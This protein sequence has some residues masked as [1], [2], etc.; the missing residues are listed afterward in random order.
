MTRTRSRRRSAARQSAWWV[1]LLKGWAAALVVTLAGVMIF[2]L[3]LQWLRPSDQA[4]RVVNQVLKLASVAVGVWVAVGRGGEGGLIRGAA[5]GLLY[6]LAGVAAY[7][8]LSHQAASLTSYLADLGMGV[9]GGGLVG[10]ILSNIS[11]K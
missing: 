10:M 9:A 1:Q 3:L 4:V 7:A 8:L 5:V 6:M 2:A 11:A